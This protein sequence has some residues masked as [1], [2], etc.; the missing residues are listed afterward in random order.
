MISMQYGNTLNEN[1]YH[2]HI[3]RTKVQTLSDESYIRYVQ[4]SFSCFLLSYATKLAISKIRVV[5]NSDVALR[6]TSNKNRTSLQ[7]L[8]K[9]FLR[10][11]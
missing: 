1:R 7:E 5:L 4:H 11:R 2:N 10:Y 8:H 9:K 6:R 3:F